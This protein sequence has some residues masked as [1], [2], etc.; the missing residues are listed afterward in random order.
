[1]QFAL[2]QTHTSKREQRLDFHLILLLVLGYKRGAD[3][4]VSVVVFSKRFMMT[5]RERKSHAQQ[6]CVWGSV[7]HYSAE[8][9]HSSRKHRVVCWRAEIAR[10]TKL[11]IKKNCQRRRVRESN[12]SCIWRGF[13][14]A[15]VN[16]VGV[17]LLS[18]C[19]VQC[20]IGELDSLWYRFYVWH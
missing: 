18:A 12:R 15:G 8:Q 13:V 9:Q 14:R 20:Y 11:A 4:S 1:M 10:A 6:L 2:H 19:T 7:F 16:E 5:W 17:A 3:N